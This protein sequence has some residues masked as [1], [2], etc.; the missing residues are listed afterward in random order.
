MPA[1]VSVH[2][3]L[4]ELLSQGLLSNTSGIRR[5]ACASLRMVVACLAMAPSR[6]WS[7]VCL[8]IARPQMLLASPCG[9][10][11]ERFL[12]TAAVKLLSR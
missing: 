11:A 8:M 3:D 2:G 12:W 5:A 1:G 10:N 4:K 6:S 9:L 7:G